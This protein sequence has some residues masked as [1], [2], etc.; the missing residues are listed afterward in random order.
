MQ[1][2]LESRPDFLD[3]IELALLALCSGDEEGGGR[4]VPLIIQKRQCGLENVTTRGPGRN[5]LPN[6]YFLGW[7]GQNQWTVKEQKYTSINYKVHGSTGI[8]EGTDLS[9]DLDISEW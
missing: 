4:A 2:S 6:D 3:T 9:L 7:Y 5:S 8:G 1:A